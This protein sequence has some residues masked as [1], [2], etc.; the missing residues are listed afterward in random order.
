MRARLPLRGARGVGE[1][2]R[3]QRGGVHGEGRWPRRRVA[4]GRPDFH[5]GVG[6]AK[7]FLTE[8]TKR[9]HFF[10]REPNTVGSHALKAAA[11]LISE[12][13]G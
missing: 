2:L 1:F 7:V 13:V 4:A 6:Q 5:G 8:L 11:L 9:A 3:R 10:G 12:R